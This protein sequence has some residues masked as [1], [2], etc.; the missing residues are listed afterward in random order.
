MIVTYGIMKASL[1]DTLI[2]V[3]EFNSISGMRPEAITLDDG[4][5]VKF[6]KADFTLLERGYITKSQY[7]ERN[8]IADKRD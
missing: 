7:I 4:Q 2:V 6:N 1:R 3:N 8:V 5:A